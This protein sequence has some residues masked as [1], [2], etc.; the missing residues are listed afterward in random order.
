MIGRNSID[1]EGKLPSFVSYLEN[2]SKRLPDSTITF[3]LE[4]I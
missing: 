3:S 2:Y 1:A 4:K